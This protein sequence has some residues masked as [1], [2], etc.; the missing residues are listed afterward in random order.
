MLGYEAQKRLPASH[1][2][3][4]KIKFKL[5]DRL[6]LQLNKNALVDTIR[7]L[8]LDVQRDIEARHLIPGKD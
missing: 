7:D 5:K 3:S 1:E 6:P 2:E 8:R 4:L